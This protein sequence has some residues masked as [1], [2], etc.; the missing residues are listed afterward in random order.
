MSRT[1]STKAYLALVL[2]LLFV[3]LSVIV[4]VLVNSS[5]R[6]LALTDAE[7]ASRMLLDHNLA[8]H[9]YFSQDLKPKLFERLSPNSSKDYFE[10]VW[11]SSTY[12]VRKMDGYFRHFN[13]SPYYYKECAINARSPENE[14]DDY[15]KTFLV[16]L[17]NSPQLMTKSAIRFLDGKPYFTFLRRGE[18]MEES[19][20]RCHSSPEQAP[21]DL[22]RQYGPDRSFHRK[23]EDVAQAISIRIPLS[24]A[25]SSATS[26]S[27]HLSVLLVV[28][29]GGG[30][31]FVWFG[32]KR[33]LISPMAKIQEQA[34]RIASEHERLGETIPEPKVRELRDLVTSFNQMSVELRKI[35]D[36]LEQRVLERTTNLGAANQRLEKEIADRK[37]AEEA[38]RESEERYRLFFETSRDGVFM[39]RLDGQFIDFNEVALEV[40][41]YAPDDRDE[42]LQTNVANAY[43]NPEEREAHA[44]LVSKQGFSKEYPLDLRK[45]DGTIIHALATTIARKDSNGRIIG[46]QGTIRDI[47]ERKRAEEELK[48]TLKRFYTILSN[49]Y[50]A[51]LLVSDEGQVEFANQA[52]CDLFDLDD[53]PSDLRGLGAVEM[54]K[55]I[56]DAYAHPAEAV[57][58]IQEVVAQQSPVR[59]EEI[60][61]RAGKTYL[62]DFIPLLVDGKRSGRLW[63]HQDI[64]NRKRSEEL[65]LQTARLRAVADLSSGVA[66]HFNNLLQIV[67]A[68]TSLSLADLESGDLSEIKTNLEKMLQAATLGAET[69]KRLQTFAN[70]RADVAEHESDVFDMSTTVRNAVD[71]SKPLWKSDPEKKGIKIDLQLDLQDGCLLKGQENEMF[72]VLVNLIRNAGEAMPQGG[73]IEVKTHKEANEV[74]ITVRDAGIGIAEDD[75]PKVFQPFWSS[76]GVGIG[77]GMGLAVSHGLVKRHGGTISVQSKVG[78]GTTFTVRLP[79]PQEQVRKTEEPAMSTA[80]DH[81]TIL[82]INDDLNIASLIERILA[83][84]GH[85]VFKALSGQEGRAIFNKEPVDL[86]ICDLGMPGMSGWDVGKAIQSICQERGITK[87]PFILLTGWGG[88]ELEKE[89]IAESGTDAVVA[90]PIDS[91]TVISTVQE[92]A[93]RFNIGARVT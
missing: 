79:L 92:I 80:G 31:L 60:A 46:F 1:F 57:A 2:G 9:T 36:E 66:H 87:P 52:F 82:V 91:A 24:E 58:S 14:A 39:T 4:V 49:L 85:R 68:S 35:Y 21:G 22:V 32:N 5:M 15:E 37:K 76:K 88:Q 89:K 67:M 63:H 38:L 41:G 55:K 54:I 7:Q 78:A 42:L 65:A 74:V 70:I 6:R 62:V 72:E 29:L 51:L 13:Q 45:K 12:A 48:N 84:A 69:V 27:Y 56:Q 20:L 8:I 16:D 23:V 59:G 93:A 25:F 18:S 10:P 40:L 44:T 61:M 81:L 73:D 28:A 50:A 43:A 26:F 19:C 3:I 90:K 17:Q 11:M 64:T 77:K 83:K 34:V 86:A 71:V 47:T 30:F 33:L 75:L 53:A